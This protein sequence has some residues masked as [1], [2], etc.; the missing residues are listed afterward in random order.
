MTTLVDEIRD[1]IEALDE[2]QQLQVLDYVNGLRKLKTA[3][4]ILAEFVAF[5]HRVQA[6]QRAK[7]GDDHYFNSVDVLNEIR[8]ERLNDIMGGR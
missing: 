7:Y 1:K 4:S 3:P 8:E 5:S 6:E 2:M